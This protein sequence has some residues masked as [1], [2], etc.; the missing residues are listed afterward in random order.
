MASLRNR[1]LK[2]YNTQRGVCLLVGLLFNPFK[3]NFINIRV[4]DGRF[5]RGQVFFRMGRGW[6]CLLSRHIFSKQCIRESSLFMCH[7]G[8]ADLGA[9]AEKSR[10]DLGGAE[11]NPVDV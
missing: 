3:G 5:K 8:A 4:G 7:R 9:G 6:S 1:K 2:N 10:R 11:K